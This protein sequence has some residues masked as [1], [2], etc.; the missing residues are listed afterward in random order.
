MVVITVLASLAPKSDVN[1]FDGKGTSALLTAG[2]FNLTPIEDNKYYT[3]YSSCQL[4]RSSLRSN[5][6]CKQ[7]SARN[8]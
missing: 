1:Y 4:S 2:I 3:E 7:K 5:Q 8:R 6:K